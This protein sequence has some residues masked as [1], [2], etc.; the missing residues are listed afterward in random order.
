MKHILVVDDNLSILKQLEA[1][2]TPSYSV[3]LANSGSLALKIARQEQPDLILLD[4]EMP[5]MDGFDTIAAIKKDPIFQHIPVI[6]LTA[7]QDTETEIKALEAGAVDFITKP[8]NK[9]ILNHRIEFHLQFSA[10]EYHL[11]HTLKN[12]EDNIV[13]SFTELVSRKGDT[14]DD[15]IPAT[16]DYVQLIGQELLNR[17]TFGAAWTET[18]LDLVVRATPF[19]DIGKIG[20]SDLILMKPGPLTPGEYEAAKKHTIIGGK[21]LGFI[22]KRNPEHLYF[23]YAQRIAQGHHERFDGLGYPEGL[24]GE[25]IPLCC[26]IVSVAN[27]YAACISKRIYRPAY[28][29]GEAQQIII[30]GKGTEFDPRI[31]EIFETVG[32]TLATLETKYDLNSTNRGKG[33]RY[34][35]PISG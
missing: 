9:D 11:E 20:I 34:E 5:D 8:V 15:H 29:H 6:F 2:L 26:R 24:A 17:G 31:V 13:R 28:T 25:A 3:S 12:L 30:A 16:R 23:K 4:V 32:D 22:Y 1:Q 35:T 18:E 21:M 19:H 14:E 33:Y 10:Y 7:N 27:V